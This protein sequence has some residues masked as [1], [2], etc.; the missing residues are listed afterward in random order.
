MG[1]GIVDFYN[2]IQ[3]RGFS[4]DFS[5]VFTDMDIFIDMD[6]ND[7]DKNDLMVYGIGAQLPAYE[8]RTE[9]LPFRGMEFNIPMT[10]RFSNS[11]SWNVEFYI[12]SKLANYFNFAVI[13]YDQFNPIT[14]YGNGTQGLY[15][16][17]VSFMVL[18]E[19][20]TPISEITLFGV[21]IKAIG[22]VKYIKTGE[23]SVQKLPLVFSYQFAN[24]KLITGDGEQGFFARIRDFG[25]KSKDVIQNT[26]RVVQEISNFRL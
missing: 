20:S 5:F 14:G 3:N 18:D 12:D 16:R 15:E 25:I 23:G 21:F 22:E 2:T 4:R 19:T 13:A 9:T 1:Q 6:L 10:T 8:T 24:F 11:E 26:R 17:K 7:S